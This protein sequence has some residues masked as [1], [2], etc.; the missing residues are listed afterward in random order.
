MTEERFKEAE[1]K[2]HRVYFLR[3]A[4]Q[5]IKG[6]EPN[7]FDI[8]SIFPIDV[9]GTMSDDEIWVRTHLKNIAQREIEKLLGDA[10]RE[11]ESL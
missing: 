5:T 2:H 11:F 10:E 4:L 7:E 6:T 9:S 1:K 3:A 8:D